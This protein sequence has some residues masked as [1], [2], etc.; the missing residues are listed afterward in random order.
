MNRVSAVV[1]VAA[2]VALPSGASAFVQTMT[3][4]P[5]GGSFACAS[6]EIPRPVRWPV[7]CISYY[8]NERGSAD[9]SGSDVI[10]ARTLA[11]IEESFTTWSEV[12]QS[13]LKLEYAGLTDEDRAEFQSAR[14]ERGNANVIMWRDEE[15]AYASTTA[16]AI[17]SVT[18]DPGT[19]LIADADI[20]LNGQHHSF[21]VGDQDV[22]VD[23]RNTLTHEVGHFIGLDH[24]GVGDAT[25]F[26]S[27]PQGETQKRTLHADDIEGLA[28]IYAPSGAS[29]Q[30][31]DLPD[32]FERPL[33]DGKEDR[34]CC[35]V[36]SGESPDAP[37]LIAIL[38][39]VVLGRRRRQ[40]LRYP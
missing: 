8:V 16:F 14:D 35:A 3:C 13:D 38:V 15:W 23:I 19:G 22:V 4:N 5:D 17:T 33:T 29:V 24:T 39:V 20:E 27:A 37:W 1:I 31:P 30:C 32:Y 34:G 10:D 11:A 26:G 9:V 25:M 21:T 18:F 2:L 7:R 28:H 40:A 6:D 12:A 36:V